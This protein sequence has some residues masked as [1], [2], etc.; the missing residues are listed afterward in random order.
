MRVV[1]L[2]ALAKERG[3]R[4]Y[5]RLRKAELIALLRD[6]LQPSTR[7]PPMPALRPSP[8]THT[9]PEGPLLPHLHCK[10]NRLCLDQIDQ[11]SQNC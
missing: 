4:S 3:L 2:K 6:N 10:R 11:D 7:P 9:R 5:S 1:D 8:A